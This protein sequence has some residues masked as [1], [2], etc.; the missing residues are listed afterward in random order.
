MGDA[1][2]MIN[3]NGKRNSDEG[4]LLMAQAVFDR[5]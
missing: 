4:R 5:V 1:L 3:Q 2:G